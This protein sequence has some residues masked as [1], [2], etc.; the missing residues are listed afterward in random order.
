MSGEPGRQY[1]TEQESK[2]SVRQKRSIY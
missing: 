2:N 1:I